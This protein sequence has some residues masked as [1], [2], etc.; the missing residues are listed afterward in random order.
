MTRKPAVH[1]CLFFLMTVD[2]ESHPEMDSFDSV[3]ALHDAVTLLTVNLL[4]DM[5]LVIKDHMLGQIVGLPPWRRRPCVVIPVLLLDLGVPGN[6][7]LVT[8]EAFLYRG[9]ARMFGTSDIGMTELTLDLFDT[10]VNTVAERDGLFR[11]DIRA[12]RQVKKIE[13][14]QYE[15]KTERAQQQG[16]PVSRH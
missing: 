9:Q 3:H 8:K 4:F 11:A 10:G 5:S 7:V 2:A 1:V 14:N 15:K 12:W 6:D 13:E 16:S